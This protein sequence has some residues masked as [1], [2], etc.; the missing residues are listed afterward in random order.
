MLC[1]DGTVVKPTGQFIQEIDRYF[2][3]SAGLARACLDG[4]KC[5]YFR[6]WL[7][8]LSKPGCY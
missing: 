2:L 4:D 6:V 5:W 1:T 7:S 3:V 8:S